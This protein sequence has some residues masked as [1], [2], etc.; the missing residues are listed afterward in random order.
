V[1]G[2]VDSLKVR[3]LQDLIA[4]N[5]SPGSFPSPA[6]LSGGPARSR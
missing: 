6:V 4:A 3:R 2:L 5:E 1:K